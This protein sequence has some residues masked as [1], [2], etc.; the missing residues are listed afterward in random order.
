MKE[1]NP[2]VSDAALPVRLPSL[3]TFDTYPPQPARRTVVDLMT[4]ADEASQVRRIAQVLATTSFVPSVYRG[5][6]DEATAAILFGR[7]V[8]IDPMH[9][10]QEISVIQGRPTV[11]ANAMRGLAQKAGVVFEVEEASDEKVVMR[12]KA[13]H[14]PKW[15]YSVWDLERARKMDLLKKENWQKQPQAMLKARC[16]TELCRLVAANVLIGLPY[17]VEEMQDEISG[18]SGQDQPARTRTVRRKV[19]AYVPPAEPELE[20]FTEPTPQMVTPGTRKALMAAFGEA[21]IHDRKTRL[22]AVSEVVSRDV[23]S[24]NELTEEEGNLVLDQ[25]RE[26]IRVAGE[27]AP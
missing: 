13:L 21:N 4:F 16:T 9:A 15:T 1:G 25:V 22:T 27:V 3:D 24:V 14:H 18:D 11:S 5:R 7:E 26:Q 12:A 20:A 10:L 6:P 17:S 23:S 8:G 2:A 19:A